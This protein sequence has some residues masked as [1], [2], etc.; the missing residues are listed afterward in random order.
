MQS[1]IDYK[2]ELY[3][4]AMQ[5]M[6]AEHKRYYNLVLQLR[7][8]EKRLLTGYKTNS[9][10]MRVFVFCWNTEERIKEFLNKQGVLI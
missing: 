2:Q 4:K 9:L 10:K 7:E 1:Q 5:K 6:S 3:L 8:C